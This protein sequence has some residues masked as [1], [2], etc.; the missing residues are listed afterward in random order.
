MSLI[1]AGEQL[2]NLADR[3]QVDR[4][5]AEMDLTGCTR[6]VKERVEEDLVYLFQ[7]P[8]I[9]TLH[10]YNGLVNHSSLLEYLPQDGMLLLDRWSQ[11]EVEAQEQEE[12]Y[13]RMRSSREERGELPGPVLLVCPTSVVSNWAREVHRFAPELTTLL[14]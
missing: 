10:F 6:E 3:Q 2:P 11:I 9:E 1:P 5:I 12:K 4:Q 8:D 14:F 7:D 13:F